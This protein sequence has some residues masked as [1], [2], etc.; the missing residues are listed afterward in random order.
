[1][2][3]LSNRLGY[4]RYYGVNPFFT[5]DIIDT[6]LKICNLVDLLKLL[7]NHFVIYLMTNHIYLENMVFF[8]T[9]NV[10]FHSQIYKD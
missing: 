3:G 7:A 8:F 6:L 1:M 2:I 4:I 5:Y 10:Q 9:S